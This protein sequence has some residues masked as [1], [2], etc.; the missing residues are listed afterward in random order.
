MISNTLNNVNEPNIFVSSKSLVN[1]GEDL[2]W[3]SRTV[4]QGQNWLDCTSFDDVRWTLFIHS[5]LIWCRQWKPIRLDQKQVDKKGV[6]HMGGF[7][8]SMPS[9]VSMFIGKLNPPVTWYQI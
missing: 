1:F 6:L 2:F 9:D 4:G 7:L 5:W 3:D 8:Y